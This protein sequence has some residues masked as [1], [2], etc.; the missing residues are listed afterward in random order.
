MAPI[1]AAIALAHLAAMAG[2]LAMATFS[3]RRVDEDGRERH[4]PDPRP[5]DV[6]D[7]SAYR[8]NLRPAPRWS[9]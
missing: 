8:Q 5:G 6:P 9:A 7:P 2:V 4:D 1:L 3:V